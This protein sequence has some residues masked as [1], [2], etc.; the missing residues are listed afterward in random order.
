M[1]SFEDLKK[2]ISIEQVADHLMLDLKK[3]GEQLRGSCPCGESKGERSFV[4]TPSKQ[5]WYSF[6]CSTGG[7]AIA[8]VAL[9]RE[10]SVKAAADELARVFAPDTPEPAGPAE[11]GFPPLPYLDASH[12]SLVALGLP[13]AVGEG[14]G[15]G[16]APKGTLRGYVCV[17]LRTPQGK[18]VG[19]LGINPAADPPFKLPSKW[20]M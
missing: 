9:V 18:L 12:P 1:V 17:P 19:Y 14:I 10:I 11:K 16:F 13:Q 4:I 2:R 20:H 6:C 5:L 8:L 15:A 7:D 3:S